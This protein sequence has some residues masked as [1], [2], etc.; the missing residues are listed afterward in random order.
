MVKHDVILA[1]ATALWSGSIDCR[2]PSSGAVL[3]TTEIEKRNKEKL[4][5]KAYIDKSK[6]EKEQKA[7][8]ISETLLRKIEEEEE[9]R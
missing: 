2:H 6:S 3:P 8:I 9:K 4:Q 1:T 7:I 5:M